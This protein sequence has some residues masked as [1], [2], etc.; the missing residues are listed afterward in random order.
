MIDGGSSVIMICFVLCRR[1]GLWRWF[2]HSVRGPISISMMRRYIEHILEILSISNL[3]DD[4]LVAIWNRIL[5]AIFRS[6]SF[7]TLNRCVHSTHFP[8]T[9]RIISRMLSESSSDKNISSIGLHVSLP[10]SILLQSLLVLSSLPSGEIT[11]TFL[12]NIWC[13]FFTH[14]GMFAGNFSPS[15]ITSEETFNM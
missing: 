4:L 15:S 14:C 1:A 8:F 6:I 7:W 5:T 11:P 10:S 9:S 2:R 12:Q 3:S 13:I